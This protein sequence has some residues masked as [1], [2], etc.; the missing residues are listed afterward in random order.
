[1][2]HDDMELENVKREKESTT[3]RRSWREAISKSKK[4]YA[5]H[6]YGRTSGVSVYW[7]RRWWRSPTSKSRCSCVQG[8]RLSIYHMWYNYTIRTCPVSF[9]YSFSNRSFVLNFD[10]ILYDCICERFGGKLWI[11]WCTIFSI[12]I[13]LNYKNSLPVVHCLYNTVIK[14]VHNRLLQKN[15]ILRP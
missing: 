13:Y 8:S 10:T 9:I 15:K 3:R 1:M 4:C 2:R 11:Y 12:N 6:W 14:C 7:W 5:C